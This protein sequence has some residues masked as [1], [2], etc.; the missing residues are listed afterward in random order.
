[1]IYHGGTWKTPEQTL[2]ECVIDLVALL[3][4]PPEVEVAQANLDDILDRLT[5]IS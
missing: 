4:Y 3:R 2:R 5:A 1:M